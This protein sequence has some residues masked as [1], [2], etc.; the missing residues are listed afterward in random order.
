M[1]R[2]D[3]ASDGPLHQQPWVKKEIENFDKQIYSLK[4]HFCSN[5][6]ELWP[7]IENV[8]VQCRKNSLKFSKLNNMVP[9]LDILPYEIKQALEN[10]TMVEEMLVSPIL[11]VMS[12]YR[13]PGG[14]LINRGFCA[15][16]SQDLEKILTILPR[17]PKDLPLWIL[18]KKKTKKTK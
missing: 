5:C 3:A 4:Q 11:A 1:K 17:L 6:H 7:S 15:N 12:V 8:C 14:A 16:F 13:L 2:F 18:K 10:L 9:D